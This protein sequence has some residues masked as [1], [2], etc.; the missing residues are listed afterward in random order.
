M[1]IPLSNYVKTNTFPNF[2]VIFVA[3]KSGW[4]GVDKKFFMQNFHTDVLGFSAAL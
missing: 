4:V 3:A 2:F 1:A